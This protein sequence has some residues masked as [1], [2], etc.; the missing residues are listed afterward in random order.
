MGIHRRLQGP[1]EAL[2]SQIRFKQCGTHREKR[3]SHGQ[4]GAGAHPVLFAEKGRRGI[5]KDYRHFLEILLKSI[6]FRFSPLST[7]LFA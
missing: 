7:R 6:L 4:T 5:L 3:N 2:G 1:T